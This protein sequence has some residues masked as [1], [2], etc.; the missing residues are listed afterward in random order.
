MK[1]SRYSF[2]FEDNNHFF[3]YNT[4]SNCF[5]ELDED[6]Y[7]RLKQSGDCNTDLVFEDDEVDIKNALELNRII[8]NND[9][10]EFLIF[11]SV[12]LQQRAENSSMHLTLAP[13]MECCFSCHYCFENSC[14]PV[15]I[16]KI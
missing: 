10:D 16:G 14:C 12:I 2:I 7:V 3:V 11:K 8:T 1:K 13:T 9:T 5:L 4:L 6:L 15:K